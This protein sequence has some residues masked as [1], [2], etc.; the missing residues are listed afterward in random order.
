MNSISEIDSSPTS[1]NTQASN[2]NQQLYSPRW[3]RKGDGGKGVKQDPRG[4][5][6]KNETKRFNKNSI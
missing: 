6:R 4:Y 1:K 5:P 3:T 2:I